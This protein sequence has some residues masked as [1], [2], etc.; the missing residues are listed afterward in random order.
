MGTPWYSKALVF[1]GFPLHH[2][3]FVYG[4][5]VLYSRNP[6]RNTA[7]PLERLAAPKGRASLAVS[8]RFASFQFFG[9]YT[10]HL[11]SSKQF[12]VWYGILYCYVM[13]SLEMSLEV[14]G[15]NKYVLM[16][17]CSK[18]T[19]KNTPLDIPDLGKRTAVTTFRCIF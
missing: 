1:H 13:L 16:K 15:L 3:Q 2:N 11:C 18:S 17:M 10:H 14:Q 6:W 9:T 7:G 19:K 5:G 12:N 8:P 4:F